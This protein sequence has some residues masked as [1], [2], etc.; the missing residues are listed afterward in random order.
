[1]KEW[2][3]QY[4]LP[5]RESFWFGGVFADSREQAIAMACD[6][7]LQFFTADTKILTIAPGR[8]TIVTSNPTPVAADACCHANQEAQ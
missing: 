2:Y 4:Q 3:A 6:Q 7:R 8:G 5:G 1:M